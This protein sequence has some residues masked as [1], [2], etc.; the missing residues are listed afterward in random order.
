MRTKGNLAR[1]EWIGLEAR[2]EASADPSQAEA[3]GRVVDETLRTVTLER[4]DGREVKVPKR[5]TRMAFALPSGERQS[6][7]L[8]ALEFRPWDRVKRAKGRAPR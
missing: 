3:S 7:D 4:R 8:G 6:L 2:V 5:G 1:H